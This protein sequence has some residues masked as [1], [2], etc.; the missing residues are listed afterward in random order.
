M[1]AGRTNIGELPKGIE[2]KG[3][4]IYNEDDRNKLFHWLIRGGNLSLA[5]DT[6]LTKD[7]FVM[8][9]HFGINTLRINFNKNEFEDPYSDGP[10]EDNLWKPYK[11]NIKKM[12]AWL[13][14]A[15]K[16]DIR[17]KCLGEILETLVPRTSEGWP[18][19]F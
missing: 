16:Y 4:G 3:I 13:L 7:D 1:V 19:Y 10:E 8:W 17:I 5:N 2:S 15:N 12:E 6:E 14:W 18:R 9:H 11:Y